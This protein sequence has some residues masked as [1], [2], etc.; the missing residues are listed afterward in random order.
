MFCGG[1]HAITSKYFD[2]CLAQWKETGARLVFY[3]DLNIQH[4][5]IEEWISRRNDEFA[6]YKDF[7]DQINAGASLKSICE[8][9]NGSTG[10]SSLYFSMKE[11][12]SKYGAFVHSTEHECDLEMARFATENKVFAVVTS[13]SDFF[14]FRGNYKFW[15]AKYMQYNKNYIST[16]AYDRNAISNI[17]GISEEQRPIFATLIGNGYMG[18]HYK[19]LTDFHYRLHDF[20][21]RSNNSKCQKQTRFHKVAQYVRQQSIRLTDETLKRISIDVFGD[22]DKKLIALIK[23]SISSY[24]INYETQEQP[25]DQFAAQLLGTPY[26]EHYITYTKDVHGFAS[27]FYDF[28]GRARNPSLPKLLIGWA[29]RKAGILRHHKRDP[30]FSLIILA[31]TSFEGKC[32]VMNEMPIYPDCTCQILLFRCI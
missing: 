1:R 16:I 19:Q 29:K 4:S 6:S 11:I 3:S 18:A 8:S 9:M 22:S 14:I 25:S 15:S 27:A 26:H 7:Y 23:E 24:D 32:I 13:D 28:R 21:R 5:K 12:A 31:Q 20:V 30:T 17:F 10:L 2:D